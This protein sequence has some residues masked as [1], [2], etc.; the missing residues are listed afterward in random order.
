MDMKK[1]TQYAQQ[2]RQAD[3]QTDNANKNHL[4]I[5]EPDSEIYIPIDENENNLEP[6]PDIAETHTDTKDEPTSSENNSHNHLSELKISEKIR[7][8]GITGADYANDFGISGEQA[9]IYI[10]L[11]DLIPEFLSML[12]DG[13]LQ[14]TEAETLAGIKQSSQLLIYRT[15]I[16]NGLKITS[17]GTA[18]L[19][20]AKRLTEENIIKALK[21]K[22]A[23]KITLP[24]EIAERYFHDMTVN[25]A[26]QTIERALNAYVKD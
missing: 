26:I 4:H 25:E 23:P 21:P 2:Q 17:K 11:N 12:D 16:D 15:I 22:P 14:I 18:E 10:Q 1:L 13:S 24:A 20:K 6:I 5:E 7:V 9:Q 19:A 8:M 3:N